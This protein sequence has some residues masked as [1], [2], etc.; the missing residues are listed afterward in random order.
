MYSHLYLFVLQ[1]P[2]LGGS[3]CEHWVEGRN[4]VFGIGIPSLV[5]RETESENSWELS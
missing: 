3:C 1:T 5:K 2:I 4:S